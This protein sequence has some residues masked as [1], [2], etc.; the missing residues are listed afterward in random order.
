MLQ[1]MGS[2]TIVITEVRE[3]GWEHLTLECDGIG[4]I[5][6]NSRTALGLP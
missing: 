6:I 1:H 5:Q 2:V 3:Q 4:L